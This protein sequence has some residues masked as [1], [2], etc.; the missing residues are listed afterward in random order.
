MTTQPWAIGMVILGTLI[1]AF[2][3]ILFKKGSANFT[4]NPKVILKNP[5][6]LL[7]NYYVIGGC[8]LYAVSA[9]IFIPAL[10]GG[11]LS[12]LY[13]LVSLTYVWVALLSM[14]FLG[15]RMNTTK[16]FGIALIILGVTFIGIGHA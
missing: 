1:G 14:K 4:I 16:W 9:F 13:P 7:K 2:G 3:P 12:V 15:E 10:R 8:F 11:E 5:L 6:M